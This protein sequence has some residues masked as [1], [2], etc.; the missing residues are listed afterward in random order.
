MCQPYRLGLYR[1]IWGIF[2]CTPDQGHINCS[3]PD[4]G[5]HYFCTPDQ[6][7]NGPCTPDQGLVYTRLGHTFFFLHQIRVRYHTFFF[8]TRLGPKF[9]K[10]T[11]QG[12]T[13]FLY[14]MQIRDYPFNLYID[15]NSHVPSKNI[16]PAIGVLYCVRARAFPRCRSLRCQRNARPSGSINDDAR[17]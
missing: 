1:Q 15:L 5:I 13:L 17:L 14:T 7:Q 10:M 2:Y 12:H 11:D 3:P 8:Y 6:G 9:P 16:W 4:Q